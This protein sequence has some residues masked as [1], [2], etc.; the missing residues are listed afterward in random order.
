MNYINTKKIFDGIK[1]MF[2]EDPIINTLTIRKNQI[3]GT[4][5]QRSS[6]PY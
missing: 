5:Y 1:Q 6:Y 3:N 4:I 2:I